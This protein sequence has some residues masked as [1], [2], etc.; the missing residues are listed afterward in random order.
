M[1]LVIDRHSDG[2]ATI[3]YVVADQAVVIRVPSYEIVHDGGDARTSVWRENKPLRSEE[4]PTMKPVA[5][6]ERGII[7]SSRRGES[8]LD[9]FGGSGSTLI[10]CERTNRF[11][12]IL[13][14]DT[15]Y[16]DVIV[17]RWEDYTGE[18]AIREDERT[19]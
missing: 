18:K 1:P 3:T 2:S 9:N 4:H 19:G 11:C 12:R 17:R 7:N 8:V 14:L 16:C 15:Y 6:I 10:A 13:E 5:L